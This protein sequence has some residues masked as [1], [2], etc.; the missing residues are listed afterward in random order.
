VSIATELSEIHRDRS[1]ALSPV[2]RL[3][4]RSPRSR[5]QHGRER[6]RTIRSPKK[7]SNV[8]ASYSAGAEIGFGW[9]LK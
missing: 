6:L 4:V 1:A 8:K 9:K 7:E 3:G 2:A 5:A